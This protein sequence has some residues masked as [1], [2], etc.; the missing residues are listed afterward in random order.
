MVEFS[1]TEILLFCWAVLATAAYLHQ[2]QESHKRG[3]LL[4]A[5]M[6]NKELRDR[7]VEDYHQHINGAKL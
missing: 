6:S 7:I 3:F 2:K 4:K 1:I 5:M